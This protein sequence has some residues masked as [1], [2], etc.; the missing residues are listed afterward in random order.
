MEQN[1][2]EIEHQVG[3]VINKMVGEF[4]RAKSDRD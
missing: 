3:V 4:Q 1:D 2:Q